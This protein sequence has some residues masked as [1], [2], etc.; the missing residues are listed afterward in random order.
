[1]TLATNT[2]NR[3]RQQVTLI[4]LPEFDWPLGHVD[5]GVIA[6]QRVTTLMQS[7]D[8]DL[9]LLQDAYRQ[10]GVLDQTIFVLMAD[11]GMMPL[12]HKVSQSDIRAAV[13]KAGTSVVAEAYSSAAYLWLKDESKAPLAAQNLVRLNNP[14]FQSVYAR[15]RTARGYTYTRITSAKLQCAPGAEAANQYLLNTFN[16]PNAPDVVVLFTEGVGC[17]PGGQAGWKAD[18]GGTSWEAQHIPLLLS[19]PGIRPGYVSSYPARLIDIAPTIL[20]AMGAS[21]KGMQ[22]I[23]LADAM[24][25]PPSWTVQ[26]QQAAGKRLT[27]V[28][29]ALQQ[30]SRLEVAA[31]L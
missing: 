18:H 26:W 24:Q 17:E 12:V 30:E 4:N 9:A 11:H 31:H 14:Y 22:G 19:G 1:M 7:F 25:A 8:R 20:Q 16:G 10:A 23:P 5:G 28:V 6:P 27:P 29:T 15:S 3:V 21:H 2:F 13:S